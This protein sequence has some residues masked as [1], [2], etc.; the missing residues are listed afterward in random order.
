M[1]AMF[2]TWQ[3]NVILL[4]QVAVDQQGFGGRQAGGLVSAVVGFD[5]IDLDQTAGAG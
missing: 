5:F 3:P 4:R 1:T 2:Y